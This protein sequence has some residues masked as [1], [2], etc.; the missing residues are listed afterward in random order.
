M[1]VC[2]EIPEISD[3]LAFWIFQTITCAKDKLYH[4]I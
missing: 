1:Y 2:S 3:N 4:V